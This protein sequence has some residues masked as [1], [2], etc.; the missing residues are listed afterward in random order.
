M[1]WAGS[2]FACFAS[3]IADI[4]R[5][6]AL[7]REHDCSSA[8]CSCRA[9]RPRTANS[10]AASSAAWP[11]SLASR[12]SAARNS[13]AAA[14]A[15]R[16]A[17]CSTTAGSFAAGRARNRSNAAFF[18]VVAVSSRSLKVGLLKAFISLQSIGSGATHAALSAEVRCEEVVRSLAP[19]LVNL[20]SGLQNTLAVLIKALKQGSFA[21]GR[22][23]ESSQGTLIKEER[24]L[25]G[26][27][28]PPKTN[29]V[30]RRIIAATGVREI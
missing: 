27:V 16:A 8:S 15:R 23:S 13:R 26:A 4:A 1:H 5:G 3:G 28:A 25:H 2:H 19:T 12:R 10:R 30:P 6:L 14:A 7:R 21:G 20:A 17:I 24:H 22:S 11:T 18:A 29:A 9:S